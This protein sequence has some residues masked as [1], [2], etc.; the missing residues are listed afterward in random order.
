MFRFL[1]LF[2]LNALYFLFIPFLILLSFK[3]KYRNSI[4]ERFFPLFNKSFEKS[5]IWFH[6]C[7]FGETR[8]I[9]PLL[10]TLENENINISVITQ[11]GYDEAKKYTKNV[12]FLP[13]EIFLPFWIKKQKVLVVLEAELWYMLFLT[14]KIRSTPTILLNARI[15]DKSYK[16]Y[17]RFAFLYKKLFQNVDYVYAQSETDKKRLSEL[18]AKNIE[19]LGN[20]KLF[21]NIK[22]E[23]RYKKPNCTVV[24]AG[25]THEG[26][27]ELI[28]NAWNSK[29][30]LIVAPRH[31]ERFA[32]VRK[33]MDEFATKNGLT[34][35]SFSKEK[36]F[37]SDLILV[38]MMGELNEIY[39]ISDLVVL[40][41]AFAKIGGH[42][43]VEPASF[44]CKIIS[45]PHFFNQKALFP[46]IENL[47]ISKEED[48][49]NYMNNIDSIKP[50]KILNSP[51][52]EIIKEK[53]LKP[54][55][56]K[57]A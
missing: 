32:G 51:D 34:F 47:V 28:L 12:R 11:T 14:A 37:K 39:A 4:R 5:G 41:G 29:G 53:I 23:Y 46:F 48:L 31:P 27:E 49:Q 9:K 44:G 10:D 18:G 55:L 40:G 3:T 2:L 26:E 8:A 19:V 25:S 24:T 38:D 45:G 22:I 54:A 57:G 16:S 1:Y 35:S 30:K 21:T 17:K 43:A 50:A 33:L 36:S 13:F 52:I 7:S 56:K 6:T 15:S 20:I 42:N